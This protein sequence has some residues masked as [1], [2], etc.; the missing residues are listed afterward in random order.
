MT[1]LALRDRC[2]NFLALSPVIMFQARLDKLDINVQT[3]L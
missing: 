3:R 2:L 1:P